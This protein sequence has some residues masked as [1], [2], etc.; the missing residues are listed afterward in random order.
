MIEPFR[1]KVS[2]ETI[3][4]LRRRLEAT[5]WPIGVS[6]SGGISLSL[7]R[8]I[9][10]YWLDKFDWTA[11]ERDINRFPHFRASLGGLRLHYIHMKSARPGARPLL[12]LHGWP[13]SF[14]EM[15]GIA[16]MLTE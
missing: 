3:A 15:L 9:T 5:R 14:V 11:Q 2:S 8:D 4:D 13:G 16:P 1:V 6:D 10:H 7:M 12:L